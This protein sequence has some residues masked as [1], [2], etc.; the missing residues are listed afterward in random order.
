ME[1]LVE[2]DV[3]ST[4]LFISSDMEMLIIGHRFTDAVTDAMGCVREQEFS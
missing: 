4:H 1:K 2:V 3:G